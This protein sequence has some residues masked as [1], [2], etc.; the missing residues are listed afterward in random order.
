M[1]RQSKEDTERRGVRGRESIIGSSLTPAIPSEPETDLSD[2][3][4][5][6]DVAEEVLL[7]RLVEQISA[8]KRHRHLAVARVHPESGVE[9][10]ARWCRS[11]IGGQDILPEL[12]VDEAAGH[13][14]EVST[15]HHAHAGID[16]MGRRQVQLGDREAG[17]LGVSLPR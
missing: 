9:Y 12:R 7:N 11:D 15:A 5:L 4:P 3:R 1:K 10:G 8:A 14:A 6:D 13:V 16:A 2:E 17:R